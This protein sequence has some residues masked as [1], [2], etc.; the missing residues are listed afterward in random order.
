MIWDEAKT[1]D[2]QGEGTDQL[3]N[4]NLAYASGK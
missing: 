3:S 1:Q 4:N 2:I